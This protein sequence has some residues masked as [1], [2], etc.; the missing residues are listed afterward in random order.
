MSLHRNLQYKRLNH[1]KE[2]E[3]PFNDGIKKQ[4]FLFCPWPFPPYALCLNFPKQHA[5]VNVRRSHWKQSSLA[6][7]LISSTP[8]K[9][10]I[11]R[12]RAEQLDETQQQCSSSSTSDGHQMNHECLSLVCLP[13]DRMKR[14]PFAIQQQS[15]S[16]CAHEPKKEPSS[17]FDL[18]F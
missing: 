18:K 15:I 11:I 8:R 14:T 13:I 12:E 16:P 2:M 4:D 7:Q 6:Q 10:G 1:R 5:Y 9:V 3:Y 17:C